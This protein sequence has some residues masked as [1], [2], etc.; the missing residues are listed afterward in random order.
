MQI[1]ALVNIV[2]YKQKDAII[3]LSNHSQKRQKDF[4]YDYG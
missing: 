4:P 1:Q 2:F 3:L